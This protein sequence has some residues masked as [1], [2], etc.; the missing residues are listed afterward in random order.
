MGSR[1]SQMRSAVRSQQC[2]RSRT[3]VS[4]RFASNT[5]ASRTV[6]ERGIVGHATRLSESGLAKSRG[7][8]GVSGGGAEMLGLDGNSGAWRPCR[9]RSDGLPSRAP[10]GNMSFPCFL[11]TF[12]RAF[13]DEGPRISGVFWSKQSGVSDAVLPRWS[14]LVVNCLKTSCPGNPPRILAMV[15]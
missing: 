5:L 4:W 14:I 10:T 12:V 9:C 1:R 2:G 7:G 13:W 11:N 15:S 3:S 8:A 6:F